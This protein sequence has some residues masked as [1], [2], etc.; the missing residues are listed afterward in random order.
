LI[1]QLRRERLPRLSIVKG[2][3][4]VEIRTGDT[5]DPRADPNSVFM[6]LALPAS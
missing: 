6:T 3:K 1:A 5:R 4:A 2:A